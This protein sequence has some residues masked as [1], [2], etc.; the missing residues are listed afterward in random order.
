MSTSNSRV[1]NQQ[2]GSS[3]DSRPLNEKPKQTYRT[4]ERVRNSMRHMTNLDWNTRP[5]TPAGKQLEMVIKI[6]E[7]VKLVKGQ[8]FVIPR[9]VGKPSEETLTLDKL[10]ETKHWDLV[11]VVEIFPENQTTKETTV[12]KA[13]GTVYIDPKDGNVEQN[14][15]IVDPRNLVSTRI[16]LF[17]NEAKPTHFLKMRTTDERAIKLDREAR[18]RFG[19]RRIADENEEKANKER[20][21]R[22]TEQ[23]K[24]EAEEEQK[25]LKAKQEEE[26]RKM[27]QIERDRAA[28]DIAGK[29]TL[30]RSNNNSN[31]NKGSRK[32]PEGNMGQSENTKESDPSGS[33]DSSESNKPSESEN[34]LSGSETGN[35]SDGESKRKEKEHHQESKSVGKKKNENNERSTYTK[36]SNMEYFTE[37]GIILKKAEA[38]VTLCF[39]PILTKDN[40]MMEGTSNKNLAEKV[41]HIIGYVRTTG[42]GSEKVKTHVSNLEF[43]EESHFRLLRA[44]GF[45]H[46]GLSTYG[47]FTETNLI[48][49]LLELPILRDAATTGA[50]VML[51]SFKPGDYSGVNFR[52]FLYNTELR[53]EWGRKPTMEGK[54]SLASAATRLGSCLTSLL[55]RAFRKTFGNV[56]LINIRPMR[57]ISDGAIRHVLEKAVATWADDV[58]ER[59]KPSRM[60]FHDWK[61]DN[62]RA[63]AKLLKA[64]VDIALRNFEPLRSLITDPAPEYPTEKMEPYPHTYFFSEMGPFKSTKNNDT[65]ERYGTSPSISKVGGSFGALSARILTRDK[66]DWKTLN[67]TIENEQGYAEGKGENSSTNNPNNTSSVKIKME[68]ANKEDKQNTHTAPKGTGKIACLWK[69]CELTKVTR[70]NGTIYTCKR[71]DETECTYSHDFTTVEEARKT[72]NKEH[73]MNWAGHDV[74]K[75]ALITN[76]SIPQ[77]W[78]E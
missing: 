22:E 52:W 44:A 64:Y 7:I 54:L 15:Q 51:R 10:V 32:K 73:F 37:R 19:L 47:G 65:N 69:L 14:E 36:G 5:T 11:E 66:W 56:E 20:K 48:H 30:K 33:D 31:K 2:I 78:K 74:I 13:L 17:R 61:V 34:S 27:E 35:T 42:Y 28:Q 43:K 57:T 29:N 12:I 45:D 41:E 58:T 59:T 3:R 18:A 68:P 60:G 24:H 53:W 50:L 72:L 38:N 49:V 40:I 26:T 70:N 9:I 23:R 67:P 71:P 1:R 39:V 6:Q 46:E 62:P 77:Q 8:T 16:H 75:D 25:R 55:H 63:A 76:G 21:E 4:H